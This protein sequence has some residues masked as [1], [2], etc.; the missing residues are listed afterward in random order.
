[1]D[2]KRRASSARRFDDSKW[3][4]SSWEAKWDANW[5]SGHSSW[6]AHA[7]S[8]RS[9]SQ[10]TD[11]IFTSQSPSPAKEQFRDKELIVRTF[12]NRARSSDHTSSSAVLAKGFK[13]RKVE[14]NI[15]V[16]AIA[17]G[18]PPTI[19]EKIVDSKK[20]DVAVEF[21]KKSVEVEKK[22]IEVKKIRSI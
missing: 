5:H 14:S 4:N 6:N 17:D 15:P 13:C 22:I 8:A 1:M 18:Q 16:A 7:S 3:D 11:E 9:D 19:V 20:K 10:F 21:K 12:G 2:W